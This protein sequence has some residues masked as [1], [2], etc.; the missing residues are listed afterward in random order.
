MQNK[1][2]STIDINNR[3]SHSI[4]NEPSKPESKLTPNLKLSENLYKRG[5]L[6]LDGHAISK[7]LHNKFK[8]KQPSFYKRH[9]ATLIFIAIASAGL[10]LYVGAGILTHGAT[11]PLFIPI[12]LKLS[13]TLGAGVGSY[14]V[15]ALL[16]GFIVIAASKAILDVF[17]TL[18]GV[19]NTIK[20]K[21]KH[22]RANSLFPYQALQISESC[23]NL[24]DSNSVMK[25]RLTT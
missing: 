23:D 13:T 10:L 3:S 17:V 4:N 22:L 1:T 25:Y 15:V 6:Q 16:V 7:N 24:Y 8:T 12:L 11:L 21:F 18:A 14:A 5:T 19:A 20:S 9:V 2:K